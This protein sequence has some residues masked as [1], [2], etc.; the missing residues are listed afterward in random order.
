MYTNCLPAVN[1]RKSR[2]EAIRKLN[3]ESQ[4]VGKA[5]VKDVERLMALGRRAVVR[6]GFSY[7]H[8]GP[9]SARA[10]EEASQDCRDFKDLFEKLRG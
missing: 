10:M 5:W 6:F 8:H 3:E 1:R 7:S 2:Q 9:I 4:W